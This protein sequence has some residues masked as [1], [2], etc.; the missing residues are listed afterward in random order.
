MFFHT[1]NCKLILGIFG[2]CR[3]ASLALHEFRL[4]PA[5]RL[6]L[7]AL[8]AQSTTAGAWSFACAAD[9]PGSSRNRRQR[10]LRN[11]WGTLSSCW[12]TCAVVGELHLIWHLTVIEHHWSG[13]VGPQSQAVPGTLH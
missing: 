1:L 4:Q 9:R 6:L 3:L 12:K 7:R 13:G 8:L 11:R 10:N 2:R 5:L